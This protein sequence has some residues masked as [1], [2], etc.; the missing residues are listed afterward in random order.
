M[1]VEERAPAEGAGLNQESIL[2][3]TD[4]IAV[5]RQMMEACY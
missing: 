4:K 3:E 2:F 1:P 5:V